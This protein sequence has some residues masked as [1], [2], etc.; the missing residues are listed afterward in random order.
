MK[1]GEQGLAPPEF[2]NHEIFGTTHYHLSYL[3]I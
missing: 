2:L 3:L 1:K